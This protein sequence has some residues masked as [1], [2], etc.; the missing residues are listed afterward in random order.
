MSRRC[1]LFLLLFLSLVFPSF[2]AI[3]Q[4]AVSSG[5]G[6]GNAVITVSHTVS[7]AN[8][9]LFVMAAQDASSTI[10]MT[11]TYNGD[12][13]TSV[14]REV[15]T[16]SQCQELFYIINPDPGTHDIVITYSNA[17]AEK[18]VLGISFTGV[19][20]TTAIGTAVGNNNNDTPLS[21][22][23]SSVAG[24]LVLGQRPQRRQPITTG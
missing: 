11:G 10:T 1:F 15:R 5:G 16:G 18:N 13:L 24:E 19:H 7:G 22:T 3:A 17:A 4:D 9:V 8:T 20:Q 14:R 2:G 21:T 6:A 12:A 23:A